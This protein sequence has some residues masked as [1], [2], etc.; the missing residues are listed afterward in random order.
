[1]QAGRN[2][3]EKRC[4]EQWE[5]KGAELRRLREELARYKS[6]LRAEAEAELVE[7]AF[8]VAKRIVRREVSVDP[9]AVRAL[10]A[11]CMRDFPAV[12]V[13]RILVHPDDLAMVREA[14]GTGVEAVGDPGVARGGAVLETDQGRLDATIDSQLEEIALGLADA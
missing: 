4:A 12:G 13:K 14:A 8:A 7:L 11:S 1:M 5:K 6:A 2:G 10:V 3:A 9:T